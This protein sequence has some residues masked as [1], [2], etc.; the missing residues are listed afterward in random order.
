MSSS[1]C[2]K[3]ENTSFEAVFDTPKGSN[4][5]LN[6]TFKNIKFESR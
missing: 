4:F 5:K 6:F 3:C 1:V 2:P